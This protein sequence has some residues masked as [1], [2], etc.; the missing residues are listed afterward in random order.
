MGKGKNASGVQGRHNYSRA[1]YLYQAAT[2]LATQVQDSHAAPSLQ[3]TGQGP[4]IQSERQKRALQ[5]MSR[6]AITD[7]RAVTLKAQ[8]RQNSDL[9]RMICKFCDT[10]QLEG[11]TSVST[12]E[13]PS[14]DGKKPWADVLVV[15]CKTCSNVK[16]YPISAPRQK[17]RSQRQDKTATASANEQKLQPSITAT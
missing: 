7:M 11:K 5:N 13:N 10:L 16:R 12:V 1:S 14:K 2:Y 9:K 8:I 6:Q 4:P 17:R 15:Q 3:Q